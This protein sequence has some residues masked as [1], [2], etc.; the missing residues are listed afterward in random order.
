MFVFSMSVCTRATLKD[1][2]KEELDKTRVNL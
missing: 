1:R 2:N